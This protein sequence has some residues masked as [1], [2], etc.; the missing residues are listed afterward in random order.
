[1]LDTAGYMIRPVTTEQLLDIWEYAAQQS[2]AHRAL[3]L[4]QSLS[5]Q[6]DDARNWTVGRRDRELMLIRQT[7][8]GDAIRGVANCPL[9]HL[10]VE[11]DFRLSDLMEQAPDGT[12]CDQ[13]ISDDFEIQWHLPTCAELAD[14]SAEAD[15]NQSRR[16]LLESCCDTIVFRGERVEL[17][18]CPESV[19]TA[20]CEAM[21][22]CD[23]LGDVQLSMHCP[24]CDR[25]WE[26]IFDISV[27]FWSELDA[28]GKRVLTEIHRLASAYGWTE[29][30]ILSLSPRRR[31][32]YLQM[33]GT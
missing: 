4:V 21:R 11:F 7:L 19:V 33:V 9:C 6:A 18:Q 32:R 20:V 2:P 8:L 29:T 17:E 10:P 26:S 28:W 1:M 5:D 31:H 22:R 13:V 15:V 24:D 3:A 14:L 12:T 23:P 30:E 27:Y 25:E 16:R